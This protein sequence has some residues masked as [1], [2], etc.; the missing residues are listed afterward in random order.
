MKYTN[1]KTTHLLYLWN[2]YHDAKK[3]HSQSIGTNL[4]ELKNGN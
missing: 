1:E 4:S 2:A 3:G